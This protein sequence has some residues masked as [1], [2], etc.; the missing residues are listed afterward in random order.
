MK[1]SQN[2]LAEQIV[3]NI[4]MKIKGLFSLLPAY[5]Y[6]AWNFKGFHF[7]VQGKILSHGNL[8]KKQKFS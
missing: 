5:V 8:Q 4:H 7:L 2:I 1:L 3:T 6:E